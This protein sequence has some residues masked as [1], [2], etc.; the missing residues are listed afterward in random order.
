MDPIENWYTSP[1]RTNNNNYSALT[2]EDLIQHIK[3]RRQE[4]WNSRGFACPLPPDVDERP[5]EDLIKLAAH[6]Y[7]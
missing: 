5:I 1:T 2:R 7:W 3:D 6:W 4:R